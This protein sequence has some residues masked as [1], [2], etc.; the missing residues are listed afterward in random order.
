M[1][2]LVKVKIEMELKADPNDEEDLKARLFDKLQFAIDE[3]DL[4][5]EVEEEEELEG[6]E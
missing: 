3:D 1:L 4:Q 6:E 5:F 2:K